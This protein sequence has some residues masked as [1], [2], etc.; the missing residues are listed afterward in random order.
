MPKRALRVLMPLLLLACAS[1]PRP[2]QP[3]D[4]MV[5]T[6]EE[7]MGT[8]ASTVYDAI[9]Q[10]RPEFLNTR[11]R[12]SIMSPAADVPRVFVDNMEMGDIEFLKSVNPSHVARV[13]RLSPEQ[14]TTRWGTGYI[15]GAILV[16]THAA[17]VRGS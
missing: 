2:S 16:T 3:H 11:G 17:E 15:G 10:L 1:M 4:R 12:S 6:G 5:I 9:R 14:A 13:E 8:H 7:L